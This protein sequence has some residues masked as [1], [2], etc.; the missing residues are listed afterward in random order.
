MEILEIVCLMTMGFCCTF[1][2]RLLD[3]VGWIQLIA[4]IGYITIVHFT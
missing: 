1:G 3:P 2:R 4:L